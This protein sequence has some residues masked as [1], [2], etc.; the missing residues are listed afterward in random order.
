VLQEI[1]DGAKDVV[2]IGRCEGGCIKIGVSFSFASGFLHDLLLKYIEQYADVRI[3]FFDGDPVEHVSAVRQ[4]RLDIAFV[5][6]DR[7]WIHCEA[8]TLWTEKIF[9]ALPDR[10]RLIENEEVCWP[11][12]S[13]ETFLVGDRPES[14]LFNYILQGKPALG[15]GLKVVN[16][17]VGRD[18]LLSLVAAGCG[19]ALVSEAS[20]VSRIPGV[21]YRSIACDRIPFSAVWLSQTDNPA[22]RRLL[23]MSREVSSSVAS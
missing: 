13:E 11:D 3:E 17:K 9:I 10:H 21:N 22:L 4:L 20:T 2:A 7:S 6:G 16:Q 15:Y 19:L 14:R 8:H 5:A 12:L 23:S 1:S 18:N